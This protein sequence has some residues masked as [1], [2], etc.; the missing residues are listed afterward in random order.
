M[1]GVTC[2]ISDSDTGAFLLSEELPKP[3]SLSVEVLKHMPKKK[4]L[5]PT[6]IYKPG[7]PLIALQCRPDP[8][9]RIQTN[10]AA[11][12]AGYQKRSQC[13]R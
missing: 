10:R 9:T 5:P 4:A 1:A 8:P 7:Q 3:I 2:L 13:L 6:Y 12:V 11:Q